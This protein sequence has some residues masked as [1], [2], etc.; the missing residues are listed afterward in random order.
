MREHHWIPNATVLRRLRLFRL[1]LAIKKDIKVLN[2][3]KSTAKKD[4]K[5]LQYGNVG[6]DANL[7]TSFTFLLII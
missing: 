6:C 3:I 1:N 4:K 7:R 2:S 5:F